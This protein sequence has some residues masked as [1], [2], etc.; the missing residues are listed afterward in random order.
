[1]RKQANFKVEER[2]SIAFLDPTENIK[3]VIEIFGDRIKQEVLARQ[4]EEK[5]ENP[6]LEEKIELSDESTIVQLKN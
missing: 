2:I 3:R 6:S 5:I 4:I 1:M